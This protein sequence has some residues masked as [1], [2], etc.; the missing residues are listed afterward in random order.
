[1]SAIELLEKEIHDFD[2]NR[3]NA[4]EDKTKDYYYIKGMIVALYEAE[5]ITDQYY[6]EKYEY[7]KEIMRGDV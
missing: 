7:V 1:M 4:D 3:E 6:R 2:N 5:I